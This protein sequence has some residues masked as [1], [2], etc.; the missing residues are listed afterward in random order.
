MTK[1]TSCDKSPRFILRAILLTIVACASFLLTNAQARAQSS[2][3]RMSNGYYMPGVVLLWNNGRFELATP[4]NTS[5]TANSYVLIHG[6]HDDATDDNFA[7]LAKAIQARDPSANVLFV[8]W[9][10]WST[11]NPDKLE[12]IVRD[13]LKW[14]AGTMGVV[15]I[16]D[17][18]DE[19]FGD[20]KAVG[21]DEY[22][23]AFALNLAVMTGRILANL[24]PVEQT[25]MIPTVADRAYALLF[26]ERNVSWDFQTNG[27]TRSFLALGLD[28]A[29]THLIGHSHGAH[30]A[31][32][33]CKRVKNKLGKT[34]KRLSALDPSTGAVHIS[35]ENAG[36]KGWDRNVA[37]FVD[38]YRT[39][40]L[41]CDGET[42]GDYNMFLYTSAHPLRNG[43]KNNIGNPVEGLNFLIDAFKTELNLHSKAISAYTL[44]V[45]KNGFLEAESFD[46][47]YQ[48]AGSARAGQWITVGN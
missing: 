9:A 38:V 7:K 29:K 6:A 44:M 33:T 46:D 27:E 16:I 40:E 39:T 26:S 2:N 45:G 41:C 10:L 43:K 31:G 1:K 23:A 47:L 42:Y 48:N 18:L 37:Q 14:L 28:P 22:K 8:D 34:V 12:E 20:G 4:N 3:P 35:G 13:Q 11:L 32:L 19:L 15:A 17:I 21:E 25:R 36:G 24:L 30:V 5:P